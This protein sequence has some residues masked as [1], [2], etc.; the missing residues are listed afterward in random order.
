MRSKTSCFNAG[1]FRKNM[2]RFAPLWLLY[3]L[4][5]LLG[6]ALMYLE[7][8]EI[9]WFAN[10]M[11]ELISISSVLNLIYAP[12]V[13]VLLFGDLYQSRMCNALH[14]MPL[15]RG[16]W[17]TTHVVS[18]LC[19]N[20]IPTAVFCAASIPLLMNTCVVNG[21]QIALWTFLGMNLSYL[22]FFGIAVFSAM[23]SGNR[24]GHIAIYALLNGG[25]FVAW[26]LVDTIYTP[27]LYGVTTPTL[28]SE[29]LTPI[30]NLMEATCLELD[31][32]H[33]VFRE[34]LTDM[35][36]HY[37][38]HGQD[39]LT[40]ALWAAVGG[41]CLLIARWL[42]KKRKL[43]CAGDTMA[44]K[45][46]EPV[47]QICAS[48]CAAALFSIFIDMFIGYVFHYEWKYLFLGTGLVIGW[49]AGKMLL[50]RSVRVFRVKNFLG[51]AA[52]AAV[53]A[54]SLAMTH[55][56][57]LGI[58]TWMP[59]VEDVKAVTFG[60]SG[61]RGMSEELT[62]DGDIQAV[63][64]L[65]ELALQDRLEE[66]GAYPIIGGTVQS[67]SA[68]AGMDE[69]TLDAL[70]F[71]YASNIYIYYQLEN[72]RTVSREYIIWGDGE[73]GRIVNEYLSRWEVVSA[74]GYYG[75]LASEEDAYT[76][77]NVL[78]NPAPEQYCTAEEVASLLA[79]IQADCEA[80]T[81]TQKSSF[82]SGKFCYRN[83]NG[84]EVTTRSIWV[85]F[86]DEN[87]RSG[88][89]NVFADSE[90]TLAWL[91]ERGLLDYTILPGNGYNG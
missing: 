77:I 26:F 51:L 72:G 15:T 83:V 50:E 11:G 38:L 87:K 37:H 90:N 24:F 71:R 70:D 10:R 74:A 52:L 32:Y 81:M 69:E 36:A 84:I 45:A 85:E 88:S 63:I 3:T 47:F 91:E 53:L 80:R 82:H 73:T 12:L 6:M 40:M 34:G 29:N 23:L 60:Y 20:L 59:Q 33:D 55:Y 44:F 28:L 76:V 7:D 56:D 4:C 43:E 79:A 1:V 78:G 62:G 17:F 86:A 66:G 9:F 58:E 48:L 67:Q 22:C 5:L 8:G 18:G 46:M 61:Y 65:Q 30:A 2:T 57:V 89:F 21:W 16:C 49:F 27:L 35:T 42:Y 31:S 39:W 54:A 68:T 41:V 19:Y 13:A 64:R 75:E 14:A 25:A